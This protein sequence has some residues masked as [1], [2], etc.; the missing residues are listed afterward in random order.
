MAS[1]WVGQLPLL[2]EAFRSALARCRPRTLLVLGCGTGNGWEHID[3]AV[4]RRVVGIDVNAEY[5]ALL[6]ERFPAPGC[7]LALRCEDLATADLPASTFDL[8]HGALILEYVDWRAL[9]PRLTRALRPAGTLSVVL[10]LPSPTVPAVTPT[11]FSSLLRLEPLFRFVEPDEFLEAA[12]SL[13]L[14][15]QERRKEVAARARRSSSS[16]CTAR[17]DHGPRSRPTSPSPP[18]PS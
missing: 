10:Q 5:L 12:Q 18:W 7:D 15:L 11:A 17:G 14:T 3:P 4:T 6:R 9:L 16:A 1:P 2:A 13:G 8:I